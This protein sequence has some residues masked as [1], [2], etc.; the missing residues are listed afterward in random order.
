MC[1]LKNNSTVKREVKSFQIGS[2]L[3]S[4]ISARLCS[5]ILVD[6]GR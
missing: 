3:T 5:C 4:C 2:T 6:P 1:L